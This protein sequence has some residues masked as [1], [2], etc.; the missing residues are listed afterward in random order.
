MPACL[1]FYP[2]DQPVRRFVLDPACEHL[3]GRGGDCDLRIVDSRMSRRHAR[4]RRV[5]DRWVLTDLASKNGIELDGRSVDEASIVDGS[6]VSFGGVLASFDVLD[7]ERLAAERTRAEGRW[8]TTINLSRRLRSDVQIDQLLRELLGAMLEISGGDRAFVMLADEAGRLAI[9]GRAAKGG[10]LP[11]DTQFPG[12]LATVQRVLAQ[13]RAVVAC[14]ARADA[15]L[16]ARPSVVTGDVRALVCLPLSIGD[17]PTG[18]VYL[19][20][21]TVGKVF[22]ELD[23]QLLEAFAAHA[24]LVIGVAA[25]QSDLAGVAALL[26]AQITRRPAADELVRRLRAVLPQPAGIVLSAQGIS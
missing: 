22:T 10:V 19:D 2:L 16:A 25:V 8:Q 26:P 5:D 14:D 11:A 15:L 13:R 9:R 23:V 24:A 7:D 12:S 1:T 20:S 18:V 21:A 6:W 17:Q 4:F 3:I